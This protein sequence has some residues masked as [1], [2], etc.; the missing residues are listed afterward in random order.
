[1]SW[2]R[3]AQ[4]WIMVLA[5]GN[6]VMFYSSPNLT[7]WTFE[8]DFGESIGAH[9]GVWECPDIFPM[10]VGNET[11]WILIVSINPG[12]PNGGSA[13]QYFVGDF[14][15]RKFT[16]TTQ[17]H[18]WIDYGKDNYAGVTWAN[19]PDERTLFIGWMSNWQYANTVP[20]HNWRSAT[21]IARELSLV[22]ENNEYWLISLPVSEFNSL[23]GTSVSL[24]KG[25]ISGEKEIPDSGSL[26]KIPCEINITFQLLEAKIPENFGVIFS[27]KNNEFIKINYETAK[28][29][30]QFDRTFSGN[31][32]F[33]N[34][35]PGMFPAP[36]IV[37]NT[38]QMQ[39][40]LDEASLEIFAQNGRTV[41]THIFFPT[42]S[43][44]RIKV[45]AEKGEVQVTEFTYTPL[46]SIW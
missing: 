29:Q 46:K 28:E 40:I 2:N 18:K 22:F 24:L 14:D 32:D 5:A 39:L 31:T 6:K 35:F 43:Y 13:T 25:F 30:L 15:G 16:P 27:N 41:L 1:V 45:F 10:Q 4:K 12:G 42:E 19:V 20:T 17:S 26:L 33:S 9:G 37:N 3:Q 8:S 44:N 7:E 21:T 38:L 34:D 11:K 23:K 36:C